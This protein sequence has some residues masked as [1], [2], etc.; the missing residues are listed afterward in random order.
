MRGWAKQ[1]GTELVPLPGRALEELLRLRLTSGEHI[2]QPA[3]ILIRP[4]RGADLI[5]QQRPEPAGVITIVKRQRV[6]AASTVPAR[7]HP[8]TVRQ[9]LQ[10]TTDRR[11]RELKDSTQLG[12]RQFVT[13]QKQQHPAAGRIR[14]CAEV[15]KNSRAYRRHSSIRKSGLMV[16]WT[17]A[18]VKSQVITLWRG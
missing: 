3:R 2:L 5:A 8:S 4:C 6:V 18:A 1:I 14:E 12:D 9:R 17:C 11:L 7:D 13:F 16:T 15:V 10:M